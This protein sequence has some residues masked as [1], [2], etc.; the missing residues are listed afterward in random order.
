MLWLKR[1]GM[2]DP[3][4]RLTRRGRTTSVIGMKSLSGCLRLVP[5]WKQEQNLGKLQIMG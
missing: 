3:G 1:V 2:G 4:G 5:N